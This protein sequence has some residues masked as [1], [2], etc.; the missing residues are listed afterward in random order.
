MKPFLLL[1]TLLSLCHAAVP[2]IRGVLCRLALPLFGALTASNIVRSVPRPGL[3]KIWCW[4]P[5]SQLQSQVH[6]PEIHLT[7]CAPAAFALPYPST[8][9]CVP[10]GL[11]VQ[12]SSNCLKVCAQDK[13]CVS[14]KGMGKKTYKASSGGDAK[15]SAALIAKKMGL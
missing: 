1:V 8:H 15:A 4:N 7:D 14:G 13:V 9:A 3:R 12:S 10:R 5:L 2:T 6:R 11:D